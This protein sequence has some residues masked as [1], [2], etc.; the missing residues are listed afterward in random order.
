[1]ICDENTAPIDI[2][3][4]SVVGNC[5][6]KCDYKFSYTNSNPTIKNNGNCLALTYDN[7]KS[8]SVKYNN[9][10]YVVS[11][12]YIYTPSLH[13]YNGEK[14]DAELIIT[15]HSNNNGKFLLVCIPITSFSSKS[16]SSELIGDIITEASNTAPTETESTVFS[17]TNF[18]LNTFIPKSSFF[19]YTATLP[20]EPCNISGVN[21]VVFNNIQ[22]SRI[23][24]NSASLATLQKIISA[25]NT[26]IKDG[27]GKLF[28]NPKG[29][30]FI[31]DENSDEIYIDCKPTG[32]S[33]EKT[34]ITKNDGSQYQMQPI[35]F[36]DFINSQ[37][38]QIFL[39]CLFFIIL[40]TIF[41]F[42]T[43]RFQGGSSSMSSLFTRKSA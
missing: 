9:D 15:H 41:V 21:Y 38:I 12:I 28:Y 20:F 33:E 36:S 19:S 1:M 31:T 37:P 13:S 4:S 42:L 24:I 34:N 14:T 25:N 32:Q 10:D 2:S 16:P 6:L 30:G 17:G 7:S 40:L 26:Q 22:D 39:G 18:N 11:E 29:S 35:S 23:N 8:V 3:A 43:S 27:S 5:E